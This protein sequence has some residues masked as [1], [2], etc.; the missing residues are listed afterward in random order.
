MKTRDYDHYRAE[1]YAAPRQT[2]HVDEVDGPDRTLV[3]GD[4]LF[5]VRT[6]HVYKDAGELHVVH[7]A[8]DGSV[9]SARSGK[10]LPVADCVPGK[11]A[12]PE[13][14]DADFARLLRDG[15]TRLTFATFDHEQVLEGPFHGLRRH[16]GQQAA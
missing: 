13:R 7:Y 2:V 10:A 14:T 9:L 16:E 15:G 3:L 12:F 8:E 6:V 1:T 5:P 4:A 11:N